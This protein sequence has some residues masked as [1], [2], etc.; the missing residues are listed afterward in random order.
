MRDGNSHFGQAS[1]PLI[2]MARLVPAIPAS[3]M[4]RRMPG[5]SPTMTVR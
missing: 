5:T 2:V 3:T 4:P 1:Q